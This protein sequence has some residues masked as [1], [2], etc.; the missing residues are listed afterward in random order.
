M[1]GPKGSKEIT[2]AN[3][4]TLTRNAS[5]GLITAIAE[6]GATSIRDMG[7]VMGALK[8]RYTGRMDF[9]RVGP[10]VKDKLG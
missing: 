7:R 9:A 3:G 8:A 4:L 5:N 2:S 1:A 10:M 6:T